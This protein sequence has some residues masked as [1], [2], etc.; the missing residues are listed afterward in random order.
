MPEFTQLQSSLNQM[1]AS[2]SAFGSFRKRWKV[3]EG[4]ARFVLVAPGTLLIWGILDWLVGLPAWPLL[5]LFGAVCGVFAFAAVKWLIPSCIGKIEP[6]SEALVLENLHGSLDNKLIGSLQLGQEVIEN[7]LVVPPSGGSEEPADRRV[8]SKKPGTTKRLGFS[9]VLVNELV[10]R[11]SDQLSSLDEK[12]LIDLTKTK[13]LLA[14]ATGI[15]LTFALCFFLSQDA[16]YQRWLRLSDAWL[17]AM[18]TLFPVTMVVHP[19]SKAVVRGRPVVLSVEVQ[20]ARRNEVRLIRIDSETSEESI[21]PLPIDSDKKASH[22][23]KDTESAFSYFFEYAGRHSSQHDILVGDLPEIKAINYEITPPVYT[24]QPMRLM[25]GRVAKL[26]GL[27]GTTVFV[28]FAANTRLHPE[29]CSIE[30][31]SGERQ[32]IDISGRFGSFDFVIDRPERIALHITGHYGE[33]FEI[34]NPLTFEI[35]VQKDRAPE[36]QMLVRR[37]AG[38]IAMSPGEASAMR[39]PYLARDDFGVQEVSIHY[40]VEAIN[41]ILGR[42][43]RKGSMIHTMDPPRDRVKGRFSGVFHGLQPPIAAG[44]RIKL[45]L[46]ARDNNTETGPGTGRSEPI[47][48]LLVGAGFGMFVDKE[49]GLM[50]R[51]DSVLLLR[52]AKK[53]KRATDLLQDAIRTVRTESPQKIKKHSVQASPG[54]STMLGESEDNIGRYFDLLSGGSRR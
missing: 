35:V 29:F 26:Q 51:R 14:G 20:G 19:G 1:R 49:F 42:G 43:K 30:W 8:P 52:M 2:L 18:D 53:V 28:S 32:R 38:E 17:T 3:L 40:E 48:I 21:T 25:T 33:G 27:A 23:V 13:K 39:I 41:E 15:V 36:I 16:V 10:I 31:A 44:D 47:E 22:E 54:Q 45:W 46:T 12:S 11:A 5:L 34:E 24:G 4:S 6:E 37:S 50:G 7:A 9:P